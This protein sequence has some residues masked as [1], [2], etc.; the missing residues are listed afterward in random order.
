M[1]FFSS[2]VKG[3]ESNETLWKRS[4]VKDLI[5]LSAIDGEIDEDEVTGLLR[6]CVELG[7]E[8]KEFKYVLNNLH[9]VKA[10][11]PDS[12]SERF[13]YI[14]TLLKMTYSD[15]YIDDNEV[16]LMMAIASNMGLDPEV[17]PALIHKIEEEAG[18]RQQ[19]EFM[20]DG[21]MRLDDAEVDIMAIV[22]NNQV[23]YV[24]HSAD[25]LFE[26]D[27]GGDKKLDG[28]IVKIS[29]KGQSNED[30]IEFFVAFDDSDSYT[31]FTLNTGR[32]E[33]LNY[34][35]SSIFKV[36]SE[37]RRFN[38]FTDS[39][40]YF[41][42][43]EYTFKLYQ[44]GNQLFLLN[45]GQTQAYLIDT[46]GIKRAEGYGEVDEVKSIFWNN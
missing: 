44:K 27:K 29:L 18:N 25:H 40:G 1:G 2:L 37:S 35:S 10:V 23:I 16:E 17:I 26:L 9:A 46:Y 45:S 36:F 12:K 24:N 34:V 43:Y 42:Q 30:L 41:S 20:S 39:E 28:R 4:L 13:E 31:M 33:R 21:G 15:G 38:L 7:M 6:F 3:R 14:M 8:G 19:D 11:Y 5:I 32:D 22:K